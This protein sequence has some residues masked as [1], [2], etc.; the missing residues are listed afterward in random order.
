MFILYRSGGSLAL[1]DEE[2][3]GKRAF[4]LYITA[5]G[6]ILSAGNKKN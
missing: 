1:E 3:E 2:G 5:I 4:S 6:R